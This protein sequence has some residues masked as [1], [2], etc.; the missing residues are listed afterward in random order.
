[1]AV[2]GSPFT[3]LGDTCPVIP[4]NVGYPH[5]PVTPTFLSPEAVVDGIPSPSFAAS[6]SSPFPTAPCDCVDMQ[7]FHLNRLNNFLAEPL[8]LRFDHSLQAIKA[9]YCTNQAFLQCGKCVKDSTNLLLTIS[10]LN[11]TLQILEFWISRETSRTMRIDPDIDIR[12]GYYEICPMEHR[13]IR[14]FLLRGLLLHCRAVLALLTTAVNTVCIGASNPIDSN[15]SESSGLPIEKSRNQAWTSTLEHCVNSM[16]DED[17]G[18]LDL[19]SGNNCLLPIVAGYEATVEAFLESISTYEC[20]CGSSSMG[21]E[22][23][24]VP[25]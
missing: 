14:L 7:L 6:L 8:P 17:P 13:K 19:G 2:D 18:A 20:I 11:L 5:T 12:Y 25:I 22:S 23:L 21:D 4:I 24:L 1:M 10:V 9:A 16:P 3:D 15:G